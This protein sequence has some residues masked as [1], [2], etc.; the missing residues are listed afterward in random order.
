MGTDKTI[1]DKKYK[2]LVTMRV[3]KK[4]DACEVVSH[5][6]SKNSHSKCKKPHKKH[7]S[8]DSSTIIESFDELSLTSTSEMSPLVPL[9]PMTS[10]EANI[11]F[12]RYINNDV[13]WSSPKGLLYG[14]ITGATNAQRANLYPDGAATY[15]VADIIMP[16][17][18]KLTLKGEYPHARYFSFTIANELGNGQLGNGTSLQDN[19]IIPDQGSINPF[20][21]SNSRDATPRNYTVHIVWGNPPKKPDVNTL[22][23]GML[24]PDQR[25]HLSI[26]YYLSDQGYD[27]TGVIKLNG[28]GSGLPVASLK[29]SS[30]S[31]ITGPDLLKVLQATKEGDPNG[32][33]TET[34][35]G[36]V[37]NSGDPTNAPACTKPSAEIF[38]NTDYSMSGQFLAKNP[39]QRVISFPPN[40]SGGFANNPA[41]EYMF[42]PISFS[43]NE[44]VVIRGKMPT[45]PDTRRGETKLPADPQLQYFSVTTSGSPPSGEGWETIFDEQIPID[46]NRFYTIVL[47]W[48]WNRPA[49]AILENGYI[50]ISPGVG[51]GHYIGARLWVVYIYFR[52]MKNNPN[53]KQSP[54]NVP[55]PTIENPI[56]QA[57]A[58]MGPYYPIAEYTTKEKFESC[59]P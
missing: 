34:W 2:T 5:N 22:Y 10:L 59:P 11:T 40:D 33:L 37:N 12:N 53:W 19:T 41:T 21:P 35:L 9:L 58:I 14:N 3:S 38:W 55:I 8:Q 43:F 49:N 29:L 16:K 27:G 54:A 20:I 45:H 4:Y 51:E 18:S 23:T 47:S 32:Y 15:F 31:T 52:F 24:Q 7:I 42:I 1:Y 26:R 13:I 44:V 50:W 46:K 28:N 48:P 25:V 30:G 56:S 39:R 17:G 36:Q 57:P 6:K